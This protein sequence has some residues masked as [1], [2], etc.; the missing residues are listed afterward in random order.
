LPFAEPKYILPSTTAGEPS[1]LLLSSEK[2]QRT[3]GVEGP[4]MLEYAVWAGSWRNI[5]QSSE[6]DSAFVGLRHARYSDERQRITMSEVKIL[7]T[8]F[9]FAYCMGLVLRVPVKVP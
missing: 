4:E 8:R 1:K 2:V 3:L 7:P 9:M 5:G 6:M